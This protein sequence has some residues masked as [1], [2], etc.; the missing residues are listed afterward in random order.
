M[1]NDP[2]TAS[3]PGTD[4][5]PAP[6]PAV[7]HDRSTDGLFAWLRENFE[8]VVVAFIMALVIRCFCIEVFKIPTGSMQPTLMGHPDT[9]DRIMVNKFI[10]HFCPVRRFDVIVFKY[11]LDTSRNFVKRAVGVGPEYLKLKDG[12]IY[13]RKPDE[14]RFA[15]AKKPFEVQ[16]RL[17]IDH[18]T[19]QFDVEHVISH[20]SVSEDDGWKVAGDQLVL[21]ASKT[22]KGEQTLHYLRSVTDYYVGNSINTGGE[23]HVGDV[24]VSAVFTIDGGTGGVTFRIYNE[25]YSFHVFLGLAGGSTLWFK[26][27]FNDTETQ[28]VPI[29]DAVLEKGRTYRAAMMTVDGTL[30]VTLDDRPVLKF[31]FITEE[32]L[33]TDTTGTDKR[34]AFGVKDAVVRID[35]L[36]IQRD[37]YYTPKGVLEHEN[38]IEIPAGRFFVIGDN[39]PNSKDSRL[40][41]RRWVKLTSGEVITGDADGEADSRNFVSEP[42]DLKRIKDVHG[43]V[44]LV[45]ESAIVADED[46]WHKFVKED[47]L[48]GKAFLVWWPLARA[49]VIR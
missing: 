39:C 17:W 12:D 21:D 37:I 24:K 3:A 22:P 8:A 2:M 4:A 6:A 36:A 9:G 43:V 11:P 30:Y 42:G 33:A 1:I 34:I 38:P 15:I 45:P 5:A 46:E 14:L 32:D 10:L 40:W 18:Y 16:E 44:R 13:V 27:T 26:N 25:P 20:W 23:N 29:K 19:S 7:A 28:P 48:V 47:E 31:D 41:K 49:K 35:R